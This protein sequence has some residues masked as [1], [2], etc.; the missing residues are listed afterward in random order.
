[1]F[2][3]FL[4]FTRFFVVGVQEACDLAGLVSTVLL[5]FVNLLLDVSEHVSVLLDLM[6]FH[7][8][9][10]TT[11]VCVHALLTEQVFGFLELVGNVAVLLALLFKAVFQ[12]VEGVLVV[13][14]LA[15]LLVLNVAR[16]DFVARLVISQHAE[17]VLSVADL[18][19]HSLQVA[20][21]LVAKG[22]E[23]LAQL[24][25]Q[26]VLL[27]NAVTGWARAKRAAACINAA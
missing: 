16:V 11:L 25:D 21:V 23:L 9:V 13:V 26:K 24:S 17:T 27:A 6:A 22:A 1:M 4:V 2:V 3:H 10:P 14:D 15:A 20:V 19:L 7:V 5:D 12:V 8:R 18:A